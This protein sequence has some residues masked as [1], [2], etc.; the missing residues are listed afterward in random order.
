MAVNKDLLAFVE[1]QMEPFG[2]VVFKKMF[3]GVGLFK[4]G[5][6]FGMIGGSVF[7][8]KVDA[9]NLD[10][11][12]SRGMEQWSPSKKGKGMPYWEVPADVLEDSGAL[13]EWAQKSFEA[14]LRAKK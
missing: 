9:E 2:D 13:K 3:G 1:D 4:D 11:Y 10:D 12:T 6:M 7:R 8:L 14:A 5:L